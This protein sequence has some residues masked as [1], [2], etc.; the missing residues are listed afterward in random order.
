MPSYYPIY[1]NLQGKRAVVVGGG[2]VAEGK[3]EKLRETG[4]VITLISPQVTPAIGRYAEDGALRWLQR[5]YQTGD[6]EGVFIAIAATNQREANQRIFEDAERLGILLNV[7]DDPP[8]CNFI[9]PSIVERGAVTLAIS[10]GGASPALAR[11]L[12]ESL[13]ESAELKWAD[14]AGVMSAARKRLRETGVS[15]DPQ[16]W[17]CCLGDDLLDL[18]QAGRETEALESLLTRLLSEH[19]AGPCA[20][21]S[22]R[23]STARRA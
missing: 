8:R 13:G 22:Q 2:S 15:V 5:E 4:A 14:M 17:Q 16:H 19:T 1:L 10:T 9:A 11:K 3:I 7:V 18:V 12:R 6:L 21:G 23:P 20:G